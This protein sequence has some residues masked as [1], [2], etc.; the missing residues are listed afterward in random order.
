MVQSANTTIV[1]DATPDFRQ[2]ML[3]HKVKKIDAL[4]I[5]HPHKDH[6]GGIDDT[7]PFQ[8]FQ[9]KPTSVYGNAMSLTGIQREIPYAF[10]E[11]TYPGVPLIDLQEINLEPFTIGDIPV[12]PIEVWH[13]KMLV[14]GFRFG[15]F[16]YITDANKIQATE[17]QKI[18]GS[19]V[20]VLN[21]LRH[22]RHIS[23]FSLSE[24]LKVVEELKVPKAYFTHISHQLGLHQ[25]VSDS[26]PQGVLLA[27]DG[28]TITI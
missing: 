22:E 3:Q 20:L 4:L 2:Q 6:V 28:L 26:L 7:R 23:H 9:G 15:K 14:Y 11:K 21:A 17:R 25:Q 10:E 5:T 8:F 1:V 16:T 18:N 24:A 27:Y 19:E 13:H 12:T